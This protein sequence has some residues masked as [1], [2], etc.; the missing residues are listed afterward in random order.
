MDSERILK[1][2]DMAKNNNISD[3]AKMMMV[4]AKSDHISVLIYRNN[5]Y[6][7]YFST[8]KCPL[9]EINNKINKVSYETGVLTPEPVNSVII[10]ITTLNKF[11]GC[12]CLTSSKNSYSHQFVQKRKSVLGLFTL[13]MMTER[14]RLMTSFK[15]N[16]TSEMFMANMSHEIRTPLNGVIGYNQLLMQTSLNM[17]QQNYLSSMNQCSIQLMQIIN[18]I[19][20]YSKLTMGKFNIHTECFSMDEIIQGVK[21]TVD[22]RLSEK[23]QRLIANV[24]SDFPK[25]IVSDKNKILQVLVNLVVN[26]SKFSDIGSSIYIIFETGGDDIVSISVKDF[27]I[28]IKDDHIE[29]IW[30]AFFQSQDGD[31]S[32]LGL[33]IS[34]KIATLLGG[35]ITVSSKRGIG[36]VFKLSIK[37]KK[38]EEYE[39]TIERDV[40][41][42][43]S[44]TVLV[45]DDN[46]DNR[47]VLSEILFE[48][49]MKPVICASALEAMRLIVGERY[50]FDIGLIDI[51]MPCISGSKL[52]EQI[53]N[54]I[55]ELPLIALSSTDSFVNTNDFEYKLDKPVN[56]IQLFNTIFNTLKKYEN[57]SVYLCERPLSSVRSSKLSTFDLN[58]LIVEDV[59]HN[60]QLLN[61]ILTTFGFDNNVIAEN[62]K[63]ALE[64]INTSKSKGVVFDLMFVDLRM[65]E[66]N[67]YEFIHNL[68]LMD[69]DCEIVVLTASVMDTDVKRCRDLGI[70]YFITKP[71]DLNQL[72]RFMLEFNEKKTQI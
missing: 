72:K 32:G 21:D 51:C 18:D 48:W 30:D 40:N 27:G 50:K 7:K 36:S 37:Y 49:K 29:N 66:M 19:L 31:G 3:M 39:K 44:K 14:V 15:S 38:F 41:Y 68:N 13:V 69:N 23:K 58:I 24:S 8:E 52:A 43:E 20:D 33:L 65:P 2:I 16:I 9:L 4:N 54:E 53:K 45:V 59:K 17:T 70:K 26:A 61:N 64:C 71:I 22:T 11:I 67:G 47:I 57:Q 12:I 25:F 35:N 56:K 60:S 62:G 46:A 42:L 5:V 34:K 1:Y 28:G 10:P 55:P 63:I 6:Y